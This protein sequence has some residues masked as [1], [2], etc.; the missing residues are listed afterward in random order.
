MNNKQLISKQIRYT[1][2]NEQTMNVISV[3]ICDEEI[4]CGLP[5][6]IVSLNN[7]SSEVALQDI[8]GL[9]TILNSFLAELSLFTNKEDFEQNKIVLEKI[10]S[11]KWMR[12]FEHYHINQ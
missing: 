12:M 9:V 10:S 7:I 2:A 8:F 6:V 5:A 11:E 3:S 1:Y 4:K